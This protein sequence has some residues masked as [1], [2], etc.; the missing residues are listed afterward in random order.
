MRKIGK[1]KFWNCLRIVVVEEMR[2]IGR[3]KFWN[4][5]RIILVEEMR[6][7]GKDKFWNC[8]V[9]FQ[10]WGF[11]FEIMRRMRVSPRGSRLVN[12]RERMNKMRAYG[13]F[14]PGYG[15]IERS[16]KRRAPEVSSVCCRILWLA[17]EGEGWRF[18]RFIEVLKSKFDWEY[19][20][21][22]AFC[23]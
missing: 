11:W 10:W 7:I 23:G 8:L 14:I 21:W 1:D 15:A 12:W 5:L 13:V 2:K 18:F 3:D 19:F 9:I 22:W 17:W 4:C 20:C 16:P 6:K